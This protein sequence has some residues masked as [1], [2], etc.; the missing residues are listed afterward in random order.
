[1]Q[2]NISKFL[3]DPTSSGTDRL[4]KRQSVLSTE[5]MEIVV[6]AAHGAGNNE[7]HTFIVI[8]C[9]AQPAQETS[10]CVITKAA[11]E[12]TTA[13]SGV[14][15]RAAAGQGRTKAK[16]THTVVTRRQR[17]NKRAIKDLTSSPESTDKASKKSRYSSHTA[18][19][20]DD[21]LVGV[22]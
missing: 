16:A 10:M 6:A 19:K 18:A 22:N 11:P 7:E 17:T 2:S 3:S 14:K 5:E 13:P 9:A 12:L 4:S 20:T 21:T 1:M 8:Q 15:T